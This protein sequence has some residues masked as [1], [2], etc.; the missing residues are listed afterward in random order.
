MRLAF[1]ICISLILFSCTEKK[2]K[3]EQSKNL[4]PKNENIE[5][6][7][8]L[9][10]LECNELIFDAGKIKKGETINHTFS[11]TNIGE[12]T[13]VLLEKTMSCNCTNLKTSNDTIQPNKSIHL[14]IEID[15]KDKN[16]GKNDATI[17]VKTNG[18]RKFYLLEVDFEVIE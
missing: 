6:I 8:S 14:D 11:F 7:P 15:T 2:V 1:I 18:K 16:I 12:E 5:F 13:V 4:P 10:I 3:K 17:T 9:G